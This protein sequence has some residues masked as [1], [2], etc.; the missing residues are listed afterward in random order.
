MAR[1]HILASWRF[2]GRTAVTSGSLARQQP[3]FFSLSNVA[4]SGTLSMK[5]RR[6]KAI[7][8]SALSR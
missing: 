3:P 1:P 8:Q 7:S 4:K 6:E 2:V 5:N